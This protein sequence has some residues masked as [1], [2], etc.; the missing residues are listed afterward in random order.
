MKNRCWYYIVLLL[1]LINTNEAI[2]QN[3]VYNPSFEEF[4]IDCNS[5]NFGAMQSSFTNLPKWYSLYSGTHFLNICANDPQFFFTVP[6]NDLGFQYP[7]T[8]NGYTSFIAYYYEDA[9]DFRGYIRGEF[10]D[11][12][13]MDTVYCVEYYLV[14]AELGS[15]GA[16]MNVDAF[17]SDTI[18]VYPPWM[19]HELLFELP[20]QIR[21]KQILNDSINWM[22]VSELYKA[23]GGERYIT[24][25]NF[26]SRER[27]TKESWSQ[28]PDHSTV[29][30]YFL[31]DVS[32]APAGVKA[33]A[34]GPDTAL[35]R[36]SMPYQLSA[37]AGYDSYEWS[38]GQTS[39][40]ID[41]YGQ[42]KYTL[43][44]SL[45][46]CGSLSDEIVITFDTPVL[47]LA[48]EKTICR[49][50]TAIISAPPGFTQYRWSNGDTSQILRTSHGGTYYLVTTDRCGTQLDSVKVM[51]DTIPTGIIKLGNDTTTCSNGKDFPIV[52]TANTNLPNYLWSNGDTTKQTTISSRGLYTLSSS[53]RCG[54]VSDEIFVDICP[55]EIAFPNAFTPNGDGLNDT[56]GPMQ[57]N[58]YIGLIQIYNRWGQL[59]FEGQSPDFN[60]DGKTGGKPAPGGI[61]AYIIHYSEYD[62]GGRRYMQKGLI[63][64][65]R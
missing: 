1:I 15:N 54:G 51:V 7:K 12:L 60:W 31:D 63:M 9:G 38:T 19:P 8:G 33:P 18:P 25:G 28:M 20:A 2:S 64:L 30:H 47:S 44:C 6:R 56:F 46:N 59:V 41:V 43:T 5:V 11:V 53:F 22:Q 57:A 52:L 32:V 58:M 27:T 40:Y 26:M 48:K 34:L 23:K 29:V 21:S 24:I 49:G 13:Q 10:N 45:G 36:N 14:L 42:G 61:Y 17:L 35:C 37:P 65:L 50:D 16:I 4:T 55:P 39:Q 3:M 62:A